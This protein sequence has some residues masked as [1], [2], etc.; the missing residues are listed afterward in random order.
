MAEMDGKNEQL[1]TAGLCSSDLKSEHHN[2]Q[3]ALND[4]THRLQ[5]LQTEHAAVTHAQRAQMDELERARAAMEKDQ[6]NDRK[7]LELLAIKQE[8]RLYVLGQAAAYICLRMPIGYLCGLRLAVLCFLFCF[9]WHS[10]HCHLLFLLLFDEVV[11]SLATNEKN[12]V[13]V[14]ADD[15]TGTLLAWT[16]AT[17]KD[18]ACPV[19]S[20]H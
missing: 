10:E 16:Q 3:L 9:L 11:L 17:R 8:R 14:V 19:V 2:L 7:A 15:R 20:E 13:V 5:Q 6:L 4:T 18:D 1:E 12:V